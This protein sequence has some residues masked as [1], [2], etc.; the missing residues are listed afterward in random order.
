[1]LPIIFL[2]LLEASP[3]SWN[4]DSTSCSRRHV[5]NQGY[6]ENRLMVLLQ[7]WYLHAGR[8][9]QID[10]L[11]LSAWNH[12]EN[13]GMGATIVAQCHLK[14]AHSFGQLALIFLLF[15]TTAT[16]LISV[17]QQQTSILPQKL[18]WISPKKHIKTAQLVASKTQLNSRLCHH[19]AP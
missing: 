5:P 14:N 9:R 7:L 11:P 4:D 3:V 1:M 2:H 10:N 6:L 19:F 13:G 12:S 18:L 16:M 17:H 8:R 15:F